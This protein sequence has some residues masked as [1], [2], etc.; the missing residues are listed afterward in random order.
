MMSNQGLPKGTIPH[1]DHCHVHGCRVICDDDTC[2]TC[3]FLIKYHRLQPCPFSKHCIFGYMGKPCVV[4]K[5]VKDEKVKNTQPSPS[6]GLTN[7]SMSS[8]IIHH[9]VSISS[10]KKPDYS[11][12][13]NQP[14]H[15]VNS[16]TINEAYKTVQIFANKKK[17]QPSWVDFYHQMNFKNCPGC[18][19]IPPNARADIHQW[20]LLLF[21]SCTPLS[22]LFHNHSIRKDMM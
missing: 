3:K 9:T 11:T 18:T 15:N 20:S 5:H 7:N 12:A 6:S 14:A 17:N 16:L 1:S 19:N 13:N 4:K 22:K 8:N 2:F 10:D 21:G